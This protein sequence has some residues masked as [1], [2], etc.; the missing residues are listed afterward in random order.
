M[1]MMDIVHTIE[2]I[3]LGMAAGK[4]PDGYTKIYPYSPKD[5][6]YLYPLPIMSTKL[7]HTHAHH[8]S[9]YLYSP[10]FK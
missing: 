5:T 3:K 9:G 10:T 8:G 7:L 2:W 6:K 1:T 4:I